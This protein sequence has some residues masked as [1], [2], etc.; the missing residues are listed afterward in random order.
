[1]KRKNLTQ[2]STEAVNITELRRNLSSYV[3]SARRGRRIQITS[4]EKVVAEL[5]PPQPGPGEA[6]DALA[7]LRGSV[8]RYDRPTDPVLDPDEWDVNNR[9]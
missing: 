2:S 6:D 8:I 4:G 9:D 5:V 1:M 7:R 3:A